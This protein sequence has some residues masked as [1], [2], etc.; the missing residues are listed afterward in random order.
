M[1][2]KNVVL[3]TLIEGVVT[4]I[5]VRTGAD[6]VIVNSS[7]NET[8]ATRLAQIATDI[9]NAVAAGITSEQVDA[10]PAMRLQLILTA[11]MRPPVILM[12]SLM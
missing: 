12:L 8:L 6:N 5:M 11:I 10:N 7:T 1:A 2:T 3:Q 4:E 9:S